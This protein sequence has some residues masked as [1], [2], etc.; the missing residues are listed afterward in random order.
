[1][2]KLIPIIGLIGIISQTISAT[3][4]YISPNGSD[5]YSGFSTSTPW[6]TFAYAIPQLIPGDTLVLMDGI[7]DL[8]NSGYISISAKNGT[9][10]SPITI[11]AEN[12]RK[13]F[14]KGDG[15]SVIHLANC[16]W[17][18]IEGLR[19]K[20]FDN[21]EFR[22]YG[23]VIR[24]EKS[25]HINLRRMLITHSNRSSNLH[26][27][28]IDGSSNVL[29]EE[30][31]LYYYHRHAIIGWGG[32]YNLTYRRNY[33]HSR[34]Y[35]DL[36]CD[37]C[38]QSGSPGR[39]SEPTS[40]YGVGNSLQ[41][42][43]IVEDSYYGATT[44]A[45][46]ATDY[47][48][49]NN[50]FL[51]N[52]SL[53]TL[54]GPQL[55]SRCGGD[56]PCPESK[57]ASGN[58]YKN[59]VVLNPSGRGFLIQD[60]INTQISNAS[61]FG[62]PTNYGIDAWHESANDAIKNDLSLYVENILIQG[63]TFGVDV[64]DYDSGDW[65]FEYIHVYDNE[66]NFKPNDIN[67]PNCFINISA[68][69]PGMYNS[70]TK[71]GCVVFVPESSPLKG[72]GKDGTDIGANVLYRYQDGVLTDE[73][74]WDAETGKFPCGAIVPGVNDIPDS[75]CFDVHERL[76]INCNECYLPYD[77]RKSL[78]TV[79]KD[80]KDF[81]SVVFPNP[82][83]S[84]SRIYLP[85]SVSASFSIQVVNSNGQIVITDEVDADYYAIGDKINTSGLYFFLIS[86]DQKIL[87]SGQFVKY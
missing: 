71:N 65:Q 17:W 13:A 83:D 48:G 77:N 3:T 72:A 24:I 69:N 37:G 30:S 81:K 12:E 87:L 41:E 86:N 56:D 55:S 28:I 2:Y 52:I 63:V 74:L 16:E 51:G 11:K 84:K 39:G 9:P 60:G 78:K 58:I 43:N 22:A 8:S 42:N 45:N 80:I 4:Y 59:T 7:Y 66:L 54:R 31:E 19:T 1:M 64:E 67:C 85:D 25:N 35:D 26:L 75:S 21:I 73:P 68:E 49:S 50:R 46:G 36:G 53:N 23:H 27:M 5:N 29:V 38:Y 62:G 57:K 34:S 10:E 6:K 76:N 70:D 14:L 79:Q 33:V 44:H 40:F 20:G 82:I 32:S 15:R 18:N 61:V 47:A